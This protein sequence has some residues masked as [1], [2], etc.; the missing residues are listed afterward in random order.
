MLPCDWLLSSV[1]RA[2]PCCNIYRYFILLKIYMH[3]ATQHV[4]VPR[5]GSEL[6]PHSGP[7]CCSDNARFLACCA[8]KECVFFIAKQYSVVWMYH[9]LF[10]H[11]LVDGHLGCFHFLDI[12]NDAAFSILVQDFVVDISFH[13]S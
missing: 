10:I 3:L 13:F 6:M 11:P 1:F 9:I 5:S 8:T 7:S 4:E 2:H 12:T